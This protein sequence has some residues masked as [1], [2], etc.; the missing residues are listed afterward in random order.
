VKNRFLMRIKNISPGIYRR[1]FVSITAR[2]I[3]V[4]ACCF[5]R[6][7]TSLKALWFLARNWK[8]ALAKRRVIQAR[9]RVDEEYMASWFQYKPVSKA[10]PKRLLRSRSAAART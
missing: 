6:E 1:N 8:K 7:Q 9:R 10:A 4:V 2:D 5:L 3:M